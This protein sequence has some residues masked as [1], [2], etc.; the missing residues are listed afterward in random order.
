M[1]RLGDLPESYEGN[2]WLQIFTDETQTGNQR[3]ED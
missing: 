2:F 1:V 3:E